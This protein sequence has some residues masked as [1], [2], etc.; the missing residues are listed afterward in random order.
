M[1]KAASDRNV[2]ERRLE[3]MME[4]V[5]MLRAKRVPMSAD[6]IHKQMRRQIKD[7][8]PEDIANFRRVFERDKED[9]RKMGVPIKVG[10]VPATDPPQ[11]GYIIRDQDYYLCDLTPQEYAAL[12]VA[13]GMVSL[14]GSSG[15]DAILRRLG[16]EGGPDSR[17]E[18]RSVSGAAKGSGSWSASLQSPAP[19]LTLFRA[20]AEHRTVKFEYDAGAG[21]TS[22]K[23]LAG[24][25]DYV[26]G[27]WY[28]TGFDYL[29]DAERTFNLRFIG[30]DLE[31]LEAGARSGG[32]AKASGSAADPVADLAV[33]PA[34]DPAAL[35]IRSKPW[36][37]PRE[38]PVT[39]KLLVESPLVGWAVRQLG[40]E[41]V[42]ERRADGGAVFEARVG[43]PEEFFRFV[44]FFLE[45]A[46]ILEPAGL[47]QR[48]AKRL[49]ALA[50]G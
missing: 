44:G 28:L 48:F 12:C 15:E 37:V 42:A 6:E 40:E 30:D 32:G 2:S 26:R 24:R 41:A 21:S 39:A 22:R 17:P 11:Q 35:G 1:N 33:D 45:D 49:E 9:L 25:L 46:E 4:L 7:C 13:R 23:V 29:R 43:D 10:T 18:S 36:E 19:L 50:Q 47:R 3:R 31:V 14:E 20:V 27:E 16:G 38:E 34:V 8:Y 5:V